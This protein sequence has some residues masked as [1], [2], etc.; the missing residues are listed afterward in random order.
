MSQSPEFTALL[1]R[2][3]CIPPDTEFN[4]RAKVYAQETRNLYFMREYSRKKRK[5]KHDSGTSLS[6]HM[7]GDTVQDF[8]GIAGT[9]LP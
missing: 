3:G 8:H 6:T 9:K 5:E 7:G 1:L 4:R 2:L